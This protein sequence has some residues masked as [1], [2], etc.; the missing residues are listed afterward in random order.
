[1][2]TEHGRA[3]D[4]QGLSEQEVL[5]QVIGAR[6]SA[7]TGNRWND[8]H[9]AYLQLI[10]DQEAFLLRRRI[11][12]HGMYGVI[13]AEGNVSD[14]WGELAHRLGHPRST[15]N[16][17]GKSVNPVHEMAHPPGIRNEEGAPEQETY[18]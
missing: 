2:A 15:V 1:M 16:R 6:D 17:W 18:R 11:V 4:S 8:C 9:A 14:I 10:A 3:A 5:E 13:K 7:I 12:L